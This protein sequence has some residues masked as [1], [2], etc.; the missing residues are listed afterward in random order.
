MWSGREGLELAIQQLHDWWKENQSYNLWRG[1]T[2]AWS[3]DMPQAWPKKICKG[4]TENRTRGAGLFPDVLQAL[5][6]CYEAHAIRK[7][8]KRENG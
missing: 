5:S 7:F 3:I 1:R 4:Q 8:W 2:S 6:P